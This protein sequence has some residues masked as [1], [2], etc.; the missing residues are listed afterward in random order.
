MA[1]IIS[2]D[3]IEDIN[4]VTKSKKAGVNGLSVPFAPV[5]IN[6]TL[7]IQTD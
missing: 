6:F 1:E 2:W 7:Y 3:I 5:S 4:S